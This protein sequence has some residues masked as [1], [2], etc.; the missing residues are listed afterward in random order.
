[1]KRFKNREEFDQFVIKTRQEGIDQ[2]LLTRKELWENL[3]KFENP[4]D[5]P[6]I[7]IL[8]DDE[9]HLY[10]EYYVPK[11]IE[12]GAIPKNKLIDDQ[13]YIGEHRRC[14]IAKWD[15]NNN[16]FKYWRHKFHMI[17]IDKCNHFEDDDG[18]AL[19]VPIKLG[20]EDEY[21]KTKE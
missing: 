7:P 2:T 1:M 3:G 21:E 10:Q 6:E 18:F 8:P 16:E 15:A 19:F 11:L 14:V 20:T 13:V 5:V 4:Q 9:K 12:A 17:F